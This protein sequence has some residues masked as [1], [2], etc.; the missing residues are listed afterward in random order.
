M[1]TDESSVGKEMSA[2]SLAKLVSAKIPDEISISTGRG[3]SSGSKKS[4]VRKAKKALKA[5]AKL[6]A[7][8]SE[9]PKS[10][11]KILSKIIPTLNS[12]N[13]PPMAPTPKMP[14]GV[15]HPSG[16]KESSSNHSS[17]PNLSH[18]HSNRPAFSLA[19][20]NRPSSSA[21]ASTHVRPNASSISSTHG[22]PSI[23]SARSSFHARPALNMARPISAHP[24][25][26]SPPN[27]IS[28]PGMHAAQS[29]RIPKF[30]TN[31]GM[32]NRITSNVRPM[33]SSARTMASSVRP[34]VSAQMQNNAT[35]SRQT[36]QSAISPRMNSPYSA[37]M[38]RASAIGSPYTA[39]PTVSSSSVSR[40]MAS[41]TN[42]ASQNQSNSTRP[43]L[44]PNGHS[45]NQP[46]NLN[47][48]ALR[49]RSL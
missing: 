49:R 39:R 35:V 37:S 31:L 25:A 44:V 46:F 41:A 12:L 43:S 17:R 14:H 32:N 38:P 34:M 27:P 47:N 10:A 22:R 45:P 5:I 4:K 2:S 20:T 30:Q 11:T 48:L 26:P 1:S 19:S 15:P 21:H 23:A 6:A 29:P 42:F 3:N 8:N 28:Y 7:N 36:M 33:A 16:L 13:A 18:A 24:E 40:P 9:T